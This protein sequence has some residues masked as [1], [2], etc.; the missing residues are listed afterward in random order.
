MMTQE[1]VDQLSEQTEV[2]VR[3]PGKPKWQE[4]RTTVD[5]VGRVAVRETKPS[6]ISIVVALDPVGLSRKHIR[7]QLPPEDEED[8][9]T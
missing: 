1:E 3:W 7:V 8:E 6:G 9:Y 2:Q 5:A 4:Y